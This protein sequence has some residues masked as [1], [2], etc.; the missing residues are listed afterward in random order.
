MV[1][2]DFKSTFTW[3]ACCA[4]MIAT[5]YVAR[6]EDDKPA[7]ET[8]ST[9]NASALRIAIV[10][11]VKVY[12][13][14]KEFVFQREKLRD[15]ARDVHAEFERRRLEF[16]NRF[17]E[18]NKM[19]MDSEEFKAARDELQKAVT[20]FQQ[21]AQRKQAEFAA[22]EAKLFEATYANISDKIE[23]VAE[24]RGIALVLQRN[25][26]FSEALKTDK[27]RTS[28]DLVSG[29]NQTVLYQTGLDITDDI[30]QAVN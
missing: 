3:L 22:A 29:L 4:C 2:P 17:A 9:A 28:Q 30:I 23:Q 14:H 26:K 5:W 25:S 1:R 18:L 13:G 24:A 27:P 12:E 11:L 6:A 20:E 10:D 21:Q 15:E 16:Q 19:K 8:A 7:G